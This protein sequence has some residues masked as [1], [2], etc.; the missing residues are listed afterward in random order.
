M[1]FHSI[2]FKKYFD[3]ECLLEP[4]GAGRGKI[5]IL[6]KHQQNPYRW[7]IALRQLPKLRYAG[8][9]FKSITLKREAPNVENIFGKSKSSILIFQNSNLK[10]RI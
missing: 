7:V 8:I 6:L 2:K 5:S 4:R 10:S 1:F 9:S 3:D